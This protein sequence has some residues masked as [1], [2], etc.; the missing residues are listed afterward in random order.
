MTNESIQTYIEDANAVKYAGQFSIRYISP[1]TGQ[2][3]RIGQRTT[4]PLK[5]REEA[6]TWID[7]KLAGVIKNEIEM[8]RRQDWRQAVTIVK[9][10]NQYKAWKQHQAPRSWAQEMSVLENFVLPYF[11]TEAGMKDPNDWHKEHQR[12]KAWL[13]DAA[14]T[15]DGEPIAISTANKAINALNKFCEWLKDHMNALD[16]HNF[17]P[18]KSHPQRL[19]KRKGADDL[20]EEYEFEIIAGNLKRSLFGDMFRVQRHTGM[21][22]NEV[23]GLSLDSLTNKIPPEIEKPFLEAGLGPIHGAIYLE[24]QPRD[25]YISREKDGSIPRMSLKWRDEISPRNSRTIPIH[26]REVWN[27]LVSRFKVA[28]S[29]YQENEYGLK[30]DSYRLFE[31]AQRNLYL[32]AIRETCEKHGLKF[33]GSHSLRHTRATELTMLGVPEKI[34]EIVMG[35]KGMSQER[36]KHIVEILNRRSQQSKDM[37]EIDFV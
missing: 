16:W 22:V 5:S 27:I 23:L 28:K 17:R 21:R 1:V 19:Q 36:Y 18:L 13:L 3:K 33:K 10:S 37:S 32:T 31:G 4:G 12:F 15:D 2:K 30:K 6:Q 35:H 24:S 29:Q 26:D 8:M 7:E 11:V 9:F 20:V 34:Q 14:K 25:A